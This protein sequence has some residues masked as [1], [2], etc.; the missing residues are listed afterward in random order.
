MSQN[1]KEAELSIQ[2]TSVRILA[3]NGS[4]T[5]TELESINDTASNSSL[6]SSTDD[7][8]ASNSQAAE[9]AARDQADYNDC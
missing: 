3:T 6:D 7:V 5:T 1:S 2:P 4:T 8:N 9:A